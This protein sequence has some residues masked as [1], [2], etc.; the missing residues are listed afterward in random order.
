[1]SAIKNAQLRYRIIDRCLTNPYRP[2]PSKE[3]LRQA[4]EEAIYGNSTGTSICHSTI[5][6]DL[7][8]MRMELD[9]P[10]RYS[11][12]ERGYY[13]EDETYS[14]DKIPLSEEDIQSIKFATNILIQF[15]RV[16]LFKQFGFAI[17]KLFD[18]IHIAGNPTEEAVDHYVQFES[19]PETAG[20]ELLSD[21][22]KAIKEKHIVQFD[23]ASFVSKKKKKRSVLPLLLKEYRN[24][25]YLISYDPSKLKVIT[26]GLDR[27]AEVQVTEK[28]F[29][30]SFDFNP[31]HYFEHSIGIT[32]N[33]N[34]PETIVFKVDKVGS[35]YLRSQPL[36]KSQK[37][38]KE[39]NS[40]DTFE[41][42]VIISEELKRTILSYG[43]QI[44]VIRPKKLR[45]QIHTII[46]EMTENYG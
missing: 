32:A 28:H 26:F 43:A 13:Y 3:M 37:M 9:A 12:V 44:E 42:N 15:K 33:D 17:D 10:I 11:R 8:A 41:L 6:K 39:G 36:H 46:S 5:E 24:R 2:F 14:I 30:E 19:F 45:S 40:R 16:A 25:W 31:D 21:L 18:R 7:F 34:Q 22:L 35:K 38:V 4:C 27:M 29:L 1:M 20:G 23:Y